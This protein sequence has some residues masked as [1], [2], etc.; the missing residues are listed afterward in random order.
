M[1]IRKNLK[2]QTKFKSDF[3]DRIK[4]RTKQISELLTQ[5]E[6]KNIEK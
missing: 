4:Y 6:L 1:I 2:N 5:T 3:E